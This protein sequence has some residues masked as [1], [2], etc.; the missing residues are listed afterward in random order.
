[1]SAATAGSTPSG[2]GDGGRL[3]D[4]RRLGHR[5]DP[6]VGQDRLPPSRRRPGPSRRR[7]CGG[8]TTGSRGTPTAGPPRHARQTPHGTSH[9]SATGWPTRSDRTPGPTASTTPAPS[10]PIAIGRRARPVAVADVQVG[11]ADARR[12]DPDAD[13]AGPRLGQLERLDRGGLAGRPQHRGPD[14]RGHV[15]LIA[16]A[17]ARAGRQVRDVGRP[18]HRAVDGAPIGVVGGR[19]PAGPPTR[20]PRRRPRARSRA[21]PRAGRRPAGRARPSRAARRSRR[22]PASGRRAG[23]SGR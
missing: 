20:S 13:L 14:V 21:T 1:M 5:A 17:L 8:G 11:V 16:P 18:P 12:E 2:S 3:R 15:S 9:D 22:R 4:D 10:W 7:A 19:C 23:T 6:A